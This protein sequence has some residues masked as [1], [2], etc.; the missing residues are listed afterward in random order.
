MCE[1]S[2]VG[3]QRRVLCRLEYCP[4]KKE[5]GSPVLCK[6]SFTFHQM[7]WPSSECG[8]PVAAI[9]NQIVNVMKFLKTWIILK[10]TS[11][12]C[13]FVRGFD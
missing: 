7:N 1:Q 6:V 3:T 11:R 13:K 12:F 2:S 10:G 5:L 9:S 4:Y 8:E